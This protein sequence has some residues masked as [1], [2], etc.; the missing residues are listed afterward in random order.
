MANTAPLF[1]AEAPG[2][3]D[4][5]LDRNGV[6]RPHWEQLALALTAMAPEEYGQRRDSAM[7]MVRE[8]GVSYNVYDEGAGLGRI[9]QLDIAPFIV[10]ADDWATIE[11]AVAAAAV[12]APQSPQKRLPSGAVIPQRRQSIVYPSASTRLPPFATAACCPKQ[13]RQRGRRNR[14]GGAIG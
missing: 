7:R 2:R 11:A 10:S 12:G 13:T 4:E 3:Y 6:V 9:W 1:G 8:N 5:V 14:G